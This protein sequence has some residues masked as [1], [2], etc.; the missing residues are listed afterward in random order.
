MKSGHDA[1]KRIATKLVRQSLLMTATVA[2]AV[3][4]ASCGGSDDRTPPVVTPPVSN[5]PPASASQTVDGFIAFL[6]TIVPTRPETSEPLDVTGFIAP[7][8]ENGDPDTAV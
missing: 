4:L 7:T 2:A 8:T 1:M 3:V 5:Q 6:K